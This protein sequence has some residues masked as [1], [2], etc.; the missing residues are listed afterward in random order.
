MKWLAWCGFVTLSLTGCWELARLEAVKPQDQGTLDNPF[1]PIV[2]REVYSQGSS[3]TAQTKLTVHLRNTNA[4]VVDEL[5][6]DEGVAQAGYELRSECSGQGG[7]L[8][9]EHK[10]Y[11]AQGYLAGPTAVSIV[12]TQDTRSQRLDYSFVV[13]D[14]PA[15]CGDGQLNPRAEACDDGN[16]V[17]GDGCDESCHW[18]SCRG[19]AV[20]VAADAGAFPAV[21]W[22]GQHYTH[23]FPAGVSSGD[24]HLQW[25][26]T[27]ADGQVLQNKRLALAHGPWSVSSPS[28]VWNAAA[29]EYGVAYI[30]FF[31]SSM[32]GVTALRLSEDGAVLSERALVP[33]NNEGTLR[34]TKIVATEGGYFILAVS[35]DGQLLT[36]FMDLSGQ[37]NPGWTPWPVA[38]VQSFDVWAGGGLIA[39]ATQERPGENGQSAIRFQVFREDGL[40]LT[41]Q[42]TVDSG[43][44]PV[45][46]L[47]RAEGY[48]L[49][50]EKLLSGANG[51]RVTEVYKS[52]VD[53]AG[54]LQGD[55]QRVLGPIAAGSFTVLEDGSTAY[56]AGSSAERKFDEWHIDVSKILLSSRP[57]LAEGNAF[58]TSLT[59]SQ[60][61]NRLRLVK[62]QT[63]R[64]SWTSQS[65]GPDGIYL[66]PLQC[67]PE[68]GNAVREVNE[69]CD[70][71]NVS[72]ADGCNA[73]CQVES[74]WQ[75]IDLPETKCMNGSSTGIGIR[76]VANAQRVMVFMQDGGACYDPVTCSCLNGRCLARHSFGAQ[77]FHGEGQPDQGWKNTQGQQGVFDVS[78]ADNPF[79]DYDQ[80]FIPYCS[81]DVFS[82]DSVT[83]IKALT[84]S[85]PTLREH[86][87][88]QNLLQAINWIQKRYQKPK[89]LVVAGSSAGGFGALLN[90]QRWQE[91]FTGTPVVI[92][93]DSSAMLDGAGA[94]L[95]GDYLPTCFQNQVDA[96]GHYG[97]RQ[98]WNMDPQLPQDC[99][100]CKTELL[101]AI[102]HFMSKHP[103]SRVGLIT[104]DA[105]W[106]I[107]FFFGRGYRQN[108]DG[109]WAYTQ[110]CNDVILPPPGQLPKLLDG[111][112]ACHEF[113]GYFMPKERFSQG[114]SDLQSTFAGWS[115]LYG[116]PAR[117]FVLQ[118]RCEHVWLYDSANLSGPLGQWVRS[119]LE[120]DPG[121]QVL[122]H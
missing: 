48:V 114:V 36:N 1:D 102:P 46:L 100:S 15:V 73:Q 83:H 70:D 80:V 11:R 68:C 104:S 76:R 54:A 90:A 27:S 9:C 61:V 122:P 16:T 7:E 60:P 35:P 101:N 111:N 29:R 116:A 95:S 87:G 121:D 10:L 53:P 41:S 94:P 69:T 109:S 37:S 4:G 113:D 66:Q 103:K 5:A 28:V 43:A 98:L 50:Y 81:G 75:W 85:G 44:G 17:S 105:D 62:D 22:N 96:S 23:V 55:S 59:L 99:E 71:G 119:L 30:A 91:S 40:P 18:E 33:Q 115:S 32:L 12:S 92:L 21:T 2:F 56:A 78:L 58:T 74:G 3:P 52:H 8:T 63:L 93:A 47:R 13:A 110:S 24:V 106:T 49:Y 26:Q 39:L 57:I 72:E 31:S 65:A 89:Q 97:I 42:T 82:G 51:P 86:R 45:K 64:L 79:R 107:R 67:G 6:I 120:G 118:N 77:R 34:L 88:H 112:A 14:L 108:A 20:Q 25:V 84:D 38:N 19:E 117:T